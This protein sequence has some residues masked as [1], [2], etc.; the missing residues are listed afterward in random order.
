MSVT[1]AILNGTKMIRN[2]RL[3][4]TITVLAMFIENN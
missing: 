3:Y 2:A 4:V 1:A